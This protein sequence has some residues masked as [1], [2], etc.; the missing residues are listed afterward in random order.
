MKQGAW[1][2]ML[3]CGLSACSVLPPN[4]QEATQVVTV[5]EPPAI[6]ANGSIFQER[7]GSL[8]LF[9][10]SRPR[11][12]GDV[13]TVVLN[14]Q[15][16]ASKNS[17]ANASRSS[18]ASLSP[19]QFP[20]G[21]TDLTKLGFDVSGESDFS[22]GGGSQANN[23]FTGTIT[24]SVL[25]VLSNG[26][27]RVGGEKQITINQGTEYI[28]FSGVVHPRAVSGLNTIPSNQ[29]ADARIEYTGDGYIN[30]AQRMG[31]LQ[32]FFLSVSPF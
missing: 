32:R 17:A 5:P 12:L 7:R 3:L 16:S 8:S 31:W 28:R 9:E 25:E 29:V 26:N 27:L 22:G 30:Q 10:D 13:L 15:V 21:L 1:I 2:G 20:D 4:R 19:N 23:S 6:V 18:S 11:R 14:E 24:V